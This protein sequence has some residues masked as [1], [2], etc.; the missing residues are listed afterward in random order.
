MPKRMK[1]WLAR[2]LPPRISFT[3]HTQNW[4]WP[5]YSSIPFLHPPFTMNMDALFDGSLTSMV[6]GAVVSIVSLNVIFSLSKSFKRDSV[7]NSFGNV[8]TGS[9]SLL[10]NKDSV[11]KREE[12]K[13]SMDGYDELFAGARKNVGS[14]HEEGSIEKRQKEYQTMV[15]SFYNLVTDF[16]EWGWG[17]VRVG[18]SGFSSRGKLGH[19]FLHPRKP[20]TRD[21][22]P[23]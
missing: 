8:V 4:K 9:V 18:K 22:S 2:I 13:D 19:S 1:L 14:L 3:R 21:F 20:P 11:L 15:N 17:Q 5:D 23:C 10:Q 7:G 16:Y 6:A 12:V